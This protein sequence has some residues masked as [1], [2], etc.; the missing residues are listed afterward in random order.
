ME[1]DLTLYLNLREGTWSH[2]MN[3]DR[4]KVK[5][6]NCIKWI[7]KSWE[8]SHQIISKDNSNLKGKGWGKDL[9]QHKS[10]MNNWLKNYK[11]YSRSME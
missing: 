2:Q 5:K 3:K 1:Q 10:Q 7:Y 8:L 9:Q 11:F 4:I 6:S